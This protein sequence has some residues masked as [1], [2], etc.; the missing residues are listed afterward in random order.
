MIAV[1]FLSNRFGRPKFSI[2]LSSAFFYPLF[3]IQNIKDELILS[4]YEWVTSVYIG[5]SIDT[6]C[7]EQAFFHE[8]TIFLLKNLVLKDRVFWNFD[9]VML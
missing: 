8:R 3:S 6:V 1:Y 5:I 9:G 4:F 7:H 2:I